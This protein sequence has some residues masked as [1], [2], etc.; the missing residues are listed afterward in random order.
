MVRSMSK[1][2]SPFEI[3]ARWV[4]C[5]LLGATM[6]M[7][8]A[9]LGCAAQSGE[10]PPPDAAPPL[11]LGRAD[12]GAATGAT[13]WLRD[14]VG[15]EIF[16]RSFADSNGDGQGD[17]KGLTR[18]LPYL[19]ELGINLVWL[20]PIHPSPSY[21]GY[22]VT[23]Y[24]QI[25]PDFGNLADFDALIQAAHQ[26]KLRVVLDLVLNHT[27]QQ[28]P[29]FT[30]A[31]AAPV[32]S[33]AAVRY[34]LRGDNP[35]WKWNGHD[36]W[37]AVTGPGAAR[38]SY[39][40]LFSGVMPD[41]N[42]RDAAT[43]HAVE[44]IATRWLRRGADG[45]RLDAARYLVESPDPVTATEVP[46]LADTADTQAVWRTLRAATQNAAPNAALIGEVWTDLDG[47]ARYRGSGDELHA[48]FNFP[49]AGALVDGLRRGTGLPVRNTLEALTHSTAPLPFFAPFLTN[50]DQRRLATELAG[51][52]Q[53]LRL[54]ASLLLAMPGT[55]FLYYG[56]EI[57]LLQSDTPGDRG[58][59]AP[60]PWAT[61]DAQRGQPDSL[62]THYQ[63]LIKLRQSTPALREAA[64]R[65]LFPSPANDG[66]LALTRG[67]SGPG[68]T[69]VLAIYNLGSTAQTGVQL[70][71]PVDYPPGAQRELLSGTTAAEVT[72]ANH[73]H[74]PLPTLAPRSA[75]WITGASVP[76][77][78]TPRRL[79]ARLHRAEKREN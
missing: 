16:V 29:W 50:H 78:A 53:L 49:L 48:A 52:P 33:A 62:L 1:P 68:K 25:H 19:A 40:G 69:P 76:P 66:L 30:Q 15:Y 14:A 67:E 7:A 2:L 45:F 34:L 51:D 8:S 26:L 13:D 35:G 39:F 74:Y 72:S 56:E 41:L 59:R 37:H 27:S 77:T 46:A 18:R 10:S 24:E 64:L 71:L 38:R 21:H 61:V 23:D 42:L 6:A 28:H 79:P 58:Q 9:E 54:A 32:G 57:G 3:V 43:V 36:V 20:T 73:D 31:T 70:A 17:L 5:G 63:R 11:D 44:D 65:L 12:L 4:R 55:P 75:L 22:D 47:I 60:M